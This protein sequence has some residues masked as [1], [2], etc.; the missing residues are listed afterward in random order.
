MFKYFI[1][2]ILFINNIFALNLTIHDSD[3]PLASHILDAEII[4]NLLII[5]GMV[6]GIEFYDISNREILNHLSNLQI[7]EGGGGSVKPNCVI[8]KDDYLYL[9]T[10]QGLG[11]VDISNPSS[12]QYLGIV[13]GTNGYILENLDIY[14]NFLAV[15]AH[16]DGVLFYDISDPDDP[17]YI[18]TYSTVNAWA[19]QLEAF[20]DHP[21]YEFVIYVADHESINIGAYQYYSN[22]HHFDGIDN[23]YIGSA[24]KDIAYGNGLVYFAAGSGGVD[25]YLAEGTINVGDIIF[26]CSMHNLCYL[27]NYDTSVLANRLSVFDNKLAVSDWD[28]VEILEWDGENLNLVGFKNTTRRTMAIATKDNYIYSA[29]WATVQIFKY[30]E[31]E[32]PDIDLNMYEL[33]YPY[34][35]NGNSNTMA[36][37]VTNNGN[38]ILV[39]DEA[40]TT[41]SEFSSSSLGDINPGETESIDITYTANSINA[42]G[43]YRIYSND[44]DESEVLC[45]VNGNIN[46][47][48]VGDQAPDFELE[49]VANGT[50][51]FKLSDYLGQIVVL[52]FFS[53]M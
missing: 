22:N 24:V 32:G 46:G 5:S 14:E 30:E 11:I 3:N 42:S 36:L 27:D 45:E 51:T 17:E 35:E 43:S 20:P 12:P 10:S 47:A 38:Q 25:V 8:A 41:N 34:V 4:D 50:G 19:V 39:V 52:A 28:D 44:T 18:H 16:E 31:I 2:L 1:I 6:G 53:P 26:D 15:A 23:I 48:N 29:E 37:D 21:N 33:N 9:T 49:I 13:S 7:S 40:Y